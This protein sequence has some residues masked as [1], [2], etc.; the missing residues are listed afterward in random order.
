MMMTVINTDLNVLLNEEIIALTLYVFLYLTYYFG[1]DFAFIKK[2][3]ERYQE[4]EDNFEKS[5]YFRRTMGFVL[6]G[7]IPFLVMLFFFDR[8]IID[9]GLG[10]PSGEGVLLWFF[11]PTSVIVIG[12]ILRPTSKIDTSYYPEVR[13]RIWTK[14]RTINNIVFW[15]LYLLGYEFAIRGF[16]FFTT[17]Y[18]FGLWPAVII[19]CVMY[20][21]IHIFKGKGEAYGAFFLGVLFC[22][23]AYY[24]NSIW[25][26]FI[27][28][29]LLAV[30]S[31]IKAVHASE[32]MEYNFK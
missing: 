21:F 14:K 15:S 5:V 17:L 25:F 13:K 23:M 30:I 31:D 6:L 22:L 18:A 28:H 4:T 20:S 29:V 19:N 12:S 1:S 9:Y 32:E 11:I 27:N 8:P 2:Y 3:R 26:V 16:V 10:L 24:T 7:L